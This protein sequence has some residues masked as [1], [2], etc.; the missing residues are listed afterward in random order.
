MGKLDCSRL[1]R[2]EG[3]IGK[4][5]G[6]KAVSFLSRILLVADPAH[7]ITLTLFH[8]TILTNQAPVVQKVDNTIHRINHYPVDS[9]V[10]FLRHLFTG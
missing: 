5:G 9:I 4:A 7:R 1:S 10:C 6:R 2:S 3:T 8:A